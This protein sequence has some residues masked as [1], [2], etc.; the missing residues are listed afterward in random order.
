MGPAPEPGDMTTTPGPLL[1]LTSSLLTDRMLT[2]SRFL[3]TLAGSTDVVVWAA[4]AENERLGSAWRAAP[5][6]VEPFPAVEP[7]PEWVNLLRR[8]DEFAWDHRLRPPSRL[9]MERHVRS[10][11]QRRRVRAMRLPGAIVAASRAC[12]VYERLLERLMLRIQR[13]EEAQRRLQQL[14]P[15]AVLT[16]NP[17]WFMEPA[18]VAEARRLGIPVMAFVPSWDNIT[19]KGRMVYG[20]DAYFVWSDTQLEELRTF[21]PRSTDVPSRAVGAPQFDVFFDDRFH[22][23]RDRF[24]CRHGLDVDLPVVVYAVGSPNFIHEHHGALRFARAV[25]RGDLGDIQV[26]IRPH[27]IHDRAQFSAD[28]LELGPRVRV[29]QV[30]EPDRA[31]VERGQDNDEIIDWVSTFRYADVV[32]NLSSTV[33]IDAAIFDRP[34]VNLDYDPAPERPNQQLVKEINREW[35]H[36]APVART[37]GLWMAEDD[38]AVIAGVRAY[39]SEPSLHRDGRRRMV[40]LVCGGTVGGAGDRFAE[41][42]ATQLG[43]DT[44]RAEDAQEGLRP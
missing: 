11:N 24:F 7:F 42:V 44:R 31:L 34:V 18:V 39:L 19:T 5:A 13:S 23:P 3:P 17:F 26:L 33:G 43:L 15:R 10:V 21:Y 2:H 32:V 22:E 1:V 35:S 28:F 41:A 27:P 40:E 38:D 9:S 4:S 25:A 14:R 16:M 29:Q 37:G 12:G 6:T 20:Y 8:L 30:A 36:F